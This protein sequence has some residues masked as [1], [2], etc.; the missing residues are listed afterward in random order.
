MS[1][2]A[3]PTKTPSLESSLYH[4]QHDERQFFQLLT[5]INDDN[6]LRD[7]I[8]A[9][10]SKAYQI[11]GYACILY[12]FRHATLRALILSRLKIARLPGYL[13]A[14]KLLEQHKHPILLDI[15][16]CFGNDTRKAVVDGWPVENV[17][18]SDLRQG[19]WDAGHELFK[20]TPASFPAAFIPGD[21]FESSMLDTSDSAAD[22]NQQPIRP[23][24][25]LASLTPLKHQISAIHASSFFHLFYEER[26]LELAKRLA[27]LLLPE[28]GSIIFGQHGSRPE[29][30]FRMEAIRK[31]QDAAQAREPMFCHSPD[32]WAK[33]WT[34]DIFGP[35]QQVRVKVDAEL[36]QVQ[37]WDFEDLDAK[38]YVMN[39]SVQV[40]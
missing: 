6:E 16:C 19:F 4:L 5:G 3:D 17:I 22:A 10:Q 7:H 39:W 14:L 24:S 40:L 29:K 31:D 9:V 25:S 11:Y 8:L 27:S 12:R 30:G 23:L 26:Q 21:I 38:F 35:H 33:L 37:R 13:K 36:Q 18:A 32:S 1:I 28:R 2:Y 15:G 20:S 34:E